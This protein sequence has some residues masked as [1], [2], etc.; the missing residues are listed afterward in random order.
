MT[1]AIITVFV[2]GYLFI[3]LE[4]L[5]KVNKAGVAILMAIACWV[6]LLMGA[7]EYGADL[8]VK[9]NTN[10]WLS[11]DLAAKLGADVNGYAG[12]MSGELFFHYLS[13]V[14]GTILFLMGA[15]TVVETVDSHGGF[16]FVKSALYTPNPK[17]LLWKVCIMTFILSAVL[18]NMT[19][20]IVMVMVLKNLIEDKATRMKFAGMVI[21]AANAG[22]AF[23]PIGDVT[24][25]MLW[26]KGC[27]ST[28]GIIKG[29]IFPSILC[30]VVPALIVMFS[31]KGEIKAPAEDATN[32]DERPLFRP[33]MRNVIFVI[34]VGGLIFVPFFHNLTGLPPFMGV[35][36]VLGLLWVATELI[37]DAHHK[38]DEQY[39]KARISSIISRIDM[40][41]IL[42]F[43]GI[44]TAVDA[45][46][47]TGSLEFLGQWLNT[48]VGNIYIV[49]SVIGIFSSIVDNVPLVASAMNMYPIADAA[50]VA[51]DA[52]MQP[53]VQDG[54]FWELLAF[55]A[56][57]GGSLLII[58]SA[59]G[60]VVM[61]LEKI[62]FIWYL[63]HFSLLALSG[64]AAGVI[65]YWF[66][67][68]VLAGLFA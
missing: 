22:G 14:C 28:I 17:A 67:K 1:T 59:A 36:L 43:L 50:T 24:T 63:K 4:S 65:W 2:V 16:G 45:V 23:S 20:S 52:A 51:A 42:F 55:C 62:N 26:I 13:E 18:D 44:L 38:N 32:S 34:G 33:D 25:I 56:G 46:A 68:T 5:T 40:S 9:A 3:A 57:T 49:D 21:I 61:G 47:A 53:Y 60:V 12:F 35:L 6:L 64:Y 54:L 27:V 15:M 31:L 58:G 10:G 7:A 19:T 66:E 39:E 11:D 29:I 8:I 37:I 41:T 48:N 30:M